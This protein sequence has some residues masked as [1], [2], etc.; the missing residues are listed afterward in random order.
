MIED[1]DKQTLWKL[2]A[3]VNLLLYHFVSGFGWSEFVVV[4][5]ADSDHWTEPVNDWNDDFSDSFAETFLG[6]LFET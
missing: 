2:K 5:M 4:S 3:R 6:S 1:N